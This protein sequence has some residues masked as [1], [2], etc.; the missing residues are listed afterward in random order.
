MLNF[1]TYFCSL[2]QVLFDF[3]ISQLPTR[4]L[5]R[6]LSR[7]RELVGNVECLKIIITFISSFLLGIIALTSH[8]DRV[9]NWAILLTT[10]AFTINR[11]A[12][13]PLS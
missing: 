6:D 8:F 12:M 10:L 4:E 1:V 11:R 13:A 5:A 2:F 9:T 7:S 3:G